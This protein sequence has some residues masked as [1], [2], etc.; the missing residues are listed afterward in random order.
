M[1]EI[2]TICI[3]IGLGALAYGMA[4]SARI[5]LAAVWKEVR[6]LRADMDSIKEGL[7]LN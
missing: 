1:A 2:V 5:D 7:G 3:D 4:R 6:A